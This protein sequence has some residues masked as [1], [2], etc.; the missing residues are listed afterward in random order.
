MTRTLLA[1]CLMISPAWGEETLMGRSV[2]FSVLAYDDPARPLFLG[3]RH[4]AVVTDGIEF[5]LVS[6]GVQNDLDVLPVLIDISA[7]RIEMTYPTAPPSTV[8]PSKFNGYVL[9]FLTD[10]LLFQSASIDQ[11]AT[12]LPL[13]EDNVFWEFGTLYINLSGFDTNTQTRVAVDFTVADC[14]I[15]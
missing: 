10:C 8:H 7:T 12:T 11:A 3:R 6:E 15:S 14:A 2:V 1:L 9:E 5:G 4:D 13:T